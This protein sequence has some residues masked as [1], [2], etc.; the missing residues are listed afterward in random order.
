M[1]ATGLV[2]SLD[3]KNGVDSVKNQRRITRLLAQINPQA[4]LIA[5]MPT[6]ARTADGPV[7]APSSAHLARYAQFETG[8]K[9]PLVLAKMAAQL[10]SDAAIDLAW[11][12]P[13]A[14]PATLDFGASPHRATA[15]IDTASGSFEHLQ[16]YLG[17]APAGVGALS[18]RIPARTAQLACSPFG[19]SGK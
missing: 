10:Q 2:T 1:G 16:G 7:A 19:S 17:D 18:M 11:V 9:D 5:R 12:E 15:V 14:I 8:V 6:A 3:Y 13:V 4:R